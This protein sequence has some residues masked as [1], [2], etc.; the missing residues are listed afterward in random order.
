[1]IP[2]N[3]QIPA[4]RFIRVK[5]KSKVPNDKDWQNSANYGFADPMITGWVRKANYGVAC[6]YGDILV[7][8]AD[9]QEVVDSVEGSGFGNTFTVKTGSG[10]RHYYYIVDSFT[11]THPLNKGKENVGH[12]RWQGGQVVGPG[13]TH[14]N[15]NRYEVLKD[16]PIAQI[17]GTAIIGLFKEYFNISVEIPITQLEAM[18]SDQKLPTVPI[19]SIISLGAL[20]KTGASTYQGPHPIHGS[21]TGLNFTIDTAKDAWY[22]FRCGSGGGPMSLIAVMNNVIQC[23][24]A[25]PGYLR[26]ELYLRTLAIAREK[27]GYKEP[28]KPQSSLPQAPLKTLKALSVTELRE[29]AKVE[30]RYIV[31]PLIPAEATILLAARPKSM[32]TYLLMDMSYAIAEGRMWLGRFLT[33]QCGVLYLDGEMGP[34]RL[35]PEPSSSPTRVWHMKIYTSSRIWG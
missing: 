8:D 28:D 35:A 11:K 7:I 34:G 27:Y 16:V 32:K 5:A 2:Q 21:T 29:L 23:Q 26:G 15:G 6:G 18:V 30:Q 31:N 3:L 17:K 1:M 13:S 9:T 22:C 24:D 10:G 20:S 4:A 14:P 33:E 25:K 19:S 12:I